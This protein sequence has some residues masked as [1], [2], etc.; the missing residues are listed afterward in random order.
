MITLTC[1]VSELVDIIRLMFEY[2]TVDS[3]MEAAEHH[4]KVQSVKP[5]ESKKL[6]TDTKELQNSHVVAVNPWDPG[7]GNGR[8]PEATYAEILKRYDAHWSV[9]SIAD[10]ME[11][12]GRRVQGICL[13]S[14]GAALRRAA[15]VESEVTSE[16]TKEAET[17]V[18][19]PERISAPEN[20]ELPSEAI[21]KPAYEVM[22][23]EVQTPE[24]KP[25][26]AKEPATQSSAA[27]KAISRQALNGMI[28]DMHVKGMTV[29]DISTSLNGQGLY[30]EEGA[31]RERIKKIKEGRG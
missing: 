12:N 31:V 28:W 18:N 17:E 15:K 11:L 3:S 22:P 25:E 20:V 13:G 30:Y 29:E 16:G 1:E 7:N 14:R 19:V 8:L 23:Q 9:K 5:K 27:P 10:S 4:E 6:S 21:Q 26:V 24:D 2:Q